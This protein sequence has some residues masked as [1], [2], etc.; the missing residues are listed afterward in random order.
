L[1]G[2]VV[3]LNNGSSLVSQAV[4]QLA[5][6]AGLRSVSLVR[7]DS[8]IEWEKLAPH[9]T[10]IGATL[11]VSEAQAG[12]HEFAKTMADLPKAKLA[13]NSSGGP[14]A[15]LLA[16]HL[17]KG[18]TL[19]TCGSEGRR[20]AI[21]APLDIFTAQDLSLRG[22]NVEAW[23][24][25][26]SKEARDKAVAEAVGSL[27]AAEGAWRLRLLVAREPFKD[28][29]VALKRTYAPGNDRQVSLTF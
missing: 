1:A 29:A 24:A 15:L 17:A 2:D 13:L 23:S 14:A 4:V 16:R 3:M 6:K 10:A 19:V 5:S 25:G 11:V 18:A 22:L 27:F 8:G 28:F 26:L 7:S 12:R 20:A 9:I 21:S